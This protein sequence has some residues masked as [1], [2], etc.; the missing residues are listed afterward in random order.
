MKIVSKA[1]LLIII[2]ITAAV[3]NLFLLYE[4]EKSGITQSYSIIRAGD[5]KVK[6]ESISSLATSVANGNVE[7]K[8]ELQKE[9]EEVQTTLTIIKNGGTLR[10]QTLA[11]VPPILRSDYNKVV[12]SWETYKSK[13][14][15]VEVTSV[16]DPEATNAM[17]YVLQKN[18]DLVLLTDNLVS[19]LENLDRNYNTH[20][21][22][23]EDLAECAK[24]IGQQSLL[25]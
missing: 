19:D 21:Q 7:D 11:Q 24:I 8:D 10:D 22:I 2:L 14:L 23:A 6:A 18:Q 16:F 3:F 5:V 9:I 12:S 13:A 20:K 25:I 15:Q 4:D 17:N 1:Y